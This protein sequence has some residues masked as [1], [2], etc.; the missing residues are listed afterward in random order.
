MVFIFYV[1]YTYS[2]WLCLTEN[3][4][5]LLTISSGIIVKSND[6]VLLECSKR[7]KVKRLTKV[8]Q[9]QYVPSLSHAIVYLLQRYPLPF[10]G[11]VYGVTKF[12]RITIR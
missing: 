6:S 1:L 11:R 3:T 12:S 9:K 7:T 10:Q 5:L 4:Y 2:I 8:E